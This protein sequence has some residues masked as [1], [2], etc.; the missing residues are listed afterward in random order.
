M[1]LPYHQ[2]CRFVPYVLMFRSSVSKLNNSSLPLPAA[3]MQWRTRSWC[4]MPLVSLTSRWKSSSRL[5]TTLTRYSDLHLCWGFG[6]Y[7]IV[8]SMIQSGRRRARREWKQQMEGTRQANESNRFKPTDSCEDEKARAKV[9]RYI[10]ILIVMVGTR[11]G[12]G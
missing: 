7:Y 12:G 2:L 11:H 8:V 9:W 10:A 5:S 3:L 6:Y 4:A 1:T